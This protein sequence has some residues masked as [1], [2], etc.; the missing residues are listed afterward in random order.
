MTDRYSKPTK[1][2]PT[3]KTTAAT[4]TTISLNGWISSYGI[5]SRCSPTMAHNLHLRF[6]RRFFVKLEITLLT[7]TECQAQS[8]GLVERFNATIDS[9]PRHY[10]SGHQRDWDSLVTSLTY[11]YSTQVHRATKLSCFS[12]ILSRHPSTSVTPTQQRMPPGADQIVF[13]TAMR[14]KIVGRAAELTR[15]A[16]KNLHKAQR[17]YKRE[18]NKRFDLNGPSRRGTMYVW[19]DRS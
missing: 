19:N 4:V 7:T 12:L 11:A 16:D 1:S 10:V 9:R 8:N 18:Q 15:M 13:A 3:A 6:A 2:T 5:P 14:I 17:H